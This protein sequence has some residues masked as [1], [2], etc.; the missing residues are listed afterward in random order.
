MNGCHNRKPFKDFVPGQDGYFMDGLTRYPKIVP[1][2]FRM[3][4]ECNYTHTALGQADKGCDG[5]TWRTTAPH[6]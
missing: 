3:S 2:R 6:L 4:R 1:V 5:C